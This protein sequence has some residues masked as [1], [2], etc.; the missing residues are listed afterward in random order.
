LSLLQIQG[1]E[2]STSIKRGGKTIHRLRSK[3]KISFLAKPIQSADKRFIA[4]VLSNEYLLVW[5]KNGKLLMQKRLK[6]LHCVNY[7][8]FKDGAVYVNAFCFDLFIKIPELIPGPAGNN[9]YATDEGVRLSKQK[10]V[11]HR[12]GEAR[13]MKNFIG[14]MALA[15][16]MHQPDI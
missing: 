10:Q 9:G 12:R 14:L 2:E 8:Q 3:Q 4:A 7:F 1:G 13:S 15:S 16:L 6:Q 5:D 11:R